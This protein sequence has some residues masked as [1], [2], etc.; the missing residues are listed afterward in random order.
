MVSLQPRLGAVQVQ[1]QETPGV[2]PPWS[3][4]MTCSSCAGRSADLLTAG[5]FLPFQTQGEVRPLSGAAHLPLAVHGNCNKCSQWWFERG[6]F[7]SVK[8][9]GW[10]SQSFMSEAAA[11]Y[12]VVMVLEPCEVKS[13]LTTLSFSEGSSKTHLSLESMRSSGLV[14]FHWRGWKTAMLICQPKLLAAGSHS[15]THM[16]TH[17]STHKTQRQTR[18]QGHS[19]NQ[20]CY[21]QRALTHYLSLH[22]CNI[23]LS[24]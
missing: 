18:A 4:N 22:N 10:W 23:L 9:F 6:I 12:R 3:N 21:S 13:P 11:R 1:V 14:S 2:F 7:P 8:R 19:T 17:T 24:R 15:H 20:A 5:L 16:Q